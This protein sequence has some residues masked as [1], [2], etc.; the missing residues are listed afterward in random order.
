MC[1]L[2]AYLPIGNSCRLSFFFGI[3][4]AR[5]YH[6]EL[7]QAGPLM[8]CSGRGIPGYGR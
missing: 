6:K 5:S 7:M 1:N 2:P 3:L 4:G 8:D